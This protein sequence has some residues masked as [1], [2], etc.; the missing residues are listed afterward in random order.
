M[1]S[2]VADSLYWMSRYLERV[3]HVARVMD[4][5]LTIVPE[6]SMEAANRR[7]SRLV[8]SLVGENYPVDSITSDFELAAL[9]T[10][11][12]DNPNSIARCIA[13][14]RENARPV[15]EQINILSQLHQSGRLH[16]RFIVQ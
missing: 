11:D 8:T 4:V 14:A 15:R 6:Q 9:L 1:L 7:R 13:A 12:E 5:H 10:F 2:R 3:D 16:A